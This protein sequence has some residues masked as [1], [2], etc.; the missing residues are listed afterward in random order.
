MAQVFHKAWNTVSKATLFGL[1]FILAAIG[2]AAATVQRSPYTTK[3]GEARMQPVPFSH[4]HHVRGLGLDCRHCHTGVE[5]S[6]FA[7]F[8]PTKT[9]MTCHSKIWTNAEMLAPV[10]ES[11][12]TGMPIVWTKVHTLPDY[13]FFNHSIHVQKGI[14]CFSCHGQVDQ[15][16]LMWKTNSLQMEWCLECHRN[17]ERYL[18]PQ[19]EVFNMNWTPQE[20]QVALGRRLIKEYDTPLSRLTDCYACHR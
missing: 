3:V 19:A 12:R 8:P 1:V 5:E 10:R 17:P 13:V 7:G 20:D 18:R 6:S 14:G 4:E 11:W 9:C 15:M 2:W 16:P